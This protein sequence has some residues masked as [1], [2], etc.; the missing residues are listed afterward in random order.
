MNEKKFITCTL[1]YGN[2]YSAH[3]GHMFEFVIGDVIARYFRNKIGDENVL[4]N[5]GLDEHGKKIYDVAI[6]NGKE[7][8]EFLDEVAKHWKEFCIKFD[9]KYNSFYRTSHPEHYKKVKK[10]WQHCVDQGL[11][12]KK[13]YTGKYCVGCESFKTE[14]DLM[15]G[16]CQDHSNLIIQEVEEE[17]YFFSLTKFQYSLVKWFESKCSV[18]PHTKHLE[19]RNLIENLED[20]SVSRQRTAVPWGIPVPND[21]EQTIYVWF[22]A[23]SNY[24]FAA[25]YEVN[26]FAN[27]KIF[28]E[29]WKNSVQIFGPDNLRF[30]AVIFQCLTQAAGVPFTGTLLCHGTILDKDGRKMSKTMGNVIDPIDQLNK[31]GCDAVRYYAIAGL[32]V[33]GNSSWSEQKLVELY[34]SHLANNYGNLVNRVIHLINKF[35][36]DMNPELPDEYRNFSI[37]LSMVC[38]FYDTYELTSAMNALNDVVSKAN[39]YITEKSPWSADSKDRDVVLR[40]LYKILIDVTYYYL[41]VIPNKANE[42]LDCLKKL[43]KVILFSKIEL[44]NQLIN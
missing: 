18:L 5:L 13:K 38:E 4:F 16:I 31:Y 6:A 14:K 21:T 30:Q 23:L 22:E 27:R 29:Y 34:N 3:A 2:S 32:Q 39:L 26:Y 44:Q 33:Y 28:D 25:G 9:I 17:N 7:L 42:A 1:P 37:M 41:P 36:V 43:E 12:Y 11:I 15:E 10:F 35:E 40:T 8:Q 19:L 20:I 24:L